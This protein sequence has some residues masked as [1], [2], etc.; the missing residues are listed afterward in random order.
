[1]TKSHTFLQKH[2]QILEK[3]LDVAQAGEQQQQEASHASR[4]TA[5]ESK[6]VIRD[7]ELESP[8]SRELFNAIL[9]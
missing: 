8:N 9:A 3:R 6:I 2:Y 1:M 7:R 4:K 5:Q